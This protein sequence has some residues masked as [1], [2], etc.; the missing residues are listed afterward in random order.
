M[1]DLAAGISAAMKDPEFSREIRYFTGHLKIVV[2][3]A[4]TVAR[5]DDGHLVFAREKDLADDRCEIVIRGTSEHFDGMLAQY[6]VPF[7]QC[8]QTTAIKHGLE[9]STTNQTFAYLP[10]LNRLVSLLRT[11]RVR[12][13]S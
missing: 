8:L 11:E 9:L 5:F 13:A 3:G 4:A 1:L 12:T 6:P 7:F 10:A 2:D